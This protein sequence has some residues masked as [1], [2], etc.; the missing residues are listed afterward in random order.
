M[1]DQGF[2]ST[3]WTLIQRIGPSSEAG[4]RAMSE[5]CEIYYEPVKHFILRWT[6]SEEKADDLT[7]SFFEQ[8]LEKNSLGQPNPEQGKFRSYLLGAVKN[9]LSAENTRNTAQKRGGNLEQMEL[10]DES[11]KDTDDHLAFDHDWALALIDRAH[12]SV[13][14]NMEKSGK[15]K[16]FE[17]LKPWLDG[18]QQ[19]DATTAA[20]QL[21]MSSNAL[22][23]AIHRLRDKFRRAIRVEI[24]STTSSAIS[25]DEEF[26]H[27]I[28]VLSTQI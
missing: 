3:R 7:H 10:K 28:E 27:L 25:A 24:E 8:L 2:R 26:S 22:N 4:T 13:A 12:Q 9:F 20:K 19:G 6:R 14:Q 18:G 1:N 15:G 5:L 17:I 23:V 16:H 21:G 11:I